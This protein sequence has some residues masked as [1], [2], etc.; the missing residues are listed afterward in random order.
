MTY[1]DLLRA[2]NGD[3]GRAYD[4]A[5]LAL[6]PGFCLP[7]CDDYRR[8]RA[9]LQSSPAD[10]VPGWLFAVRRRVLKRWSARAAAEGIPRALRL[11][12]PRLVAH[13][14]QR[15]GPR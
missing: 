1:Q 14:T 7:N 15:R 12:G 4:L 10:A 13:R 3:A 8:A 2:A 6:L 9:A 11:T 5:R